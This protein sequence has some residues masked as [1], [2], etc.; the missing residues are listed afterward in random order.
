MARFAPVLNGV[1]RAMSGI[2]EARVQPV[3]PR[4]TLGQVGQASHV[5]R[6]PS[7]QDHSS[8]R[9]Q[10]VRFDT[11]IE[12]EPEPEPGLGIQA[13]TNS[14]FHGMFQV[15]LVGEDDVVDSDDDYELPD[16][17]YGP[18]GSISAEKT[19]KKLVDRIM[20]IPAEIRKYKDSGGN[21]IDFSFELGTDSEDPEFLTLIYFILEYIK[22]CLKKQIK[23]GI[24][25]NMETTCFI[26]TKIPANFSVKIEV[27]DRTLNVEVSTGSGWWGRKSSS[28]SINIRQKD[29]YRAYIKGI[30]EMIRSGAGIRS[31]AQVKK[32][33]KHTKN[34][35]KHTKNKK[36]HTKK[37]KKKNTKQKKNTKRRR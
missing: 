18:D 2:P 37:R 25:S 13:T 34:K 20:A 8:Y 15:P 12:P 27:K 4:A 36:K 32:K 24:P 16:L 14:L 9:E 28:S 29:M 1:G 5:S 10:Q 30:K 23:P 19:Q 6:T 22:Q 7:M 17:D 3:A 26:E 33:K 21:C 11:G 35:K 31:K